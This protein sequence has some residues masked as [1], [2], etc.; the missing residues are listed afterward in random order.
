MPDEIP[1]I[2]HAFYRSESDKKVGG[3]GLG[4]PAA[5]TIIRQHGGSISVEIMPGIGPVS[6]VRLPKHKN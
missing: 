4:L 1:Y 6:T 5:N 3:H 2:F